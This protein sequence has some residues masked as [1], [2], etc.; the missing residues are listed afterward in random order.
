LFLLFFS[1]AQANLVHRSLLQTPTSFSNFTS[2]PF[3][4]NSTCPNNCSFHGI[5][6]EANQ[7]DCYSSYVYDDCSYKQKSRLTAFLLSFFLGTFAIDRF[8]L[9]YKWQSALKLILGIFVCCLCCTAY[10]I[11]KSTRNSNLQS[12]V[13]GLSWCLLN[14]G[15]FV[16]WLTD[17]ILIGSGNL[18]DGNGVST[19]PDM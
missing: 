12:L 17:V 7:C 9:G 6:T 3:S 15:T 13:L 19:A 4:S 5:C 1:L 8:Y 14:L 18:G 2:T 16:W 11:V 10:S